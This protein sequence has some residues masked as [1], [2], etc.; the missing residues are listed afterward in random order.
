MSAA[1]ILSL[2]ALG[3]QAMPVAQ[4]NTDGNVFLSVSDYPPN[5]PFVQASCAGS[6]ISH[7]VDQIWSDTA[8]ADAWNWA[9]GRWNQGANRPDG[10]NLNFTSYFSHQF[11]GPQLWECGTFGSLSN[12]IQTLGHCGDQKGTSGDVNVPGAYVILNS[13]VQ[14]HNVHQTI[15][16]DLGAV[17]SNMQ[18]QIGP[19]QSTFSPKKDL[20]IDLW[21]EI[22]DVLGFMTG[23]FYAGVWNSVMKDVFKNIGSD[24]HGE[25]KDAYNTLISQTITAASRHLPSQ[26]NALGIQ[27]DLAASLGAIA[28]FWQNFIA[29]ANAELFSGASDS[30]NALFGLINGGAALNQLTIGDQDVLST[31]ETILYAY[32]I[33]QAW[34]ISPQDLHPVIIASPGDDCTSYAQ[35]TTTGKIMNDDT[36]ARTHVC[37]D[38]V[39]YYVVNAKS[40]GTVEPL[41]GGDFNTLSNGNWGGVRLDDM[42]I[43]SLAAYK[44]NNNA[45]GYSRPDITTLLGGGDSIDSDS[46]GLTNSIRTPGFFNIPICDSV[47]TF[48]QNLGAGNP[49]MANWPCF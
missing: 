44:N 3:A 24:K 1:L 9:V 49:S 36:A 27:N 13:F 21:K 48:Q 22:L 20:P 4:A 14:I 29:E 17:Q 16:D 46:L 26:T 33:P 32:M 43:S 23:F 42:V 31:V 40:D 2:F 47:D 19:F 11:N 28:N 30:L 5:S 39:I 35:P 7:P 38:N 34:A 6:D 18:T 45:N 10:A 15:H 41:P 12:C 25:V 37:L 8:A